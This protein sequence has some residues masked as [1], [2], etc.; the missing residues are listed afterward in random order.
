MKL[1]N[2]LLLNQFSQPKVK[3]FLITFLTYSAI[4]TNRTSW[5]YVKNTF[6]D[7]MDITVEF[8]GTLDMIFL[9]SYAISLNSIGNYSNKI[10]VKYILSF[11]VI[12]TSICVL[13]ISLLRFL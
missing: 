9:L 12:M 8:L 1:F 13:S 6:K 2:F 7:D 3:V 10:N 4:Y 11:S 5:S